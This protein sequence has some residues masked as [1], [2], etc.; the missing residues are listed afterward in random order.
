VDPTSA[1]DHSVL[2]ASQLAKEVIMLLL[3]GNDT[4]SD[5][6]IVGIYQSVKNTSVHKQLTEELIAAFSSHED[7]TYDKVKKLPYLVR[8]V[9]LTRTRRNL[10]MCF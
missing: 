4:T 3:V 6:I 9:S 7:I 10:L 8:V 5:A 1:K 2:D